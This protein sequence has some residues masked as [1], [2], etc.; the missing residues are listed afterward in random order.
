MRSRASIAARTPSLAAIRASSAFYDLSLRAPFGIKTTEGP[1]Y[2]RVAWQHEHGDNRA[3]ADRPVLSRVQLR[4]PRAVNN[5]NGFLFVDHIGNICPSGFLPSARG[6]VREGSLAET[7]REDLVF[8]GLREPDLLTGKCGR[9]RFRT[10]CGGSRSRAYAETGNMFA[11]DS[12]CSYV[13]GTPI[14][15]PIEVPIGVRG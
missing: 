14:E 9:C 8:R 4:E 1:H 7:Y 13:P 10:I 11:S 2:R 6:I 12:L 3:G 5:G 15:T